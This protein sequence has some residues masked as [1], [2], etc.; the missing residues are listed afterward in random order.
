MIQRTI[1]ANVMGHQLLSVRENA[2][3]QMPLPLMENKITGTAQHVNGGFGAHADQIPA[4]HPVPAG[5]KVGVVSILPVLQI[6]QLIGSVN[7]LWNH[8]PGSCAGGLIKHHVVHLP[9]S[10]R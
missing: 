8:V 2:G 10:S 7:V 1:R 5:N 9:P 3:K 6:K 4:L